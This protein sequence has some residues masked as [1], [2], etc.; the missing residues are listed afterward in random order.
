MS[1]N[2][3]FLCDDN[4]RLSPMAEAYLNVD[5]SRG[6]RAFS[7]GLSPAPDLAEGVGKILAAHGLSLTGL[8]P[9]SWRLF[10]LAHAPVPDV[11]VGLTP[12]ALGATGRAWPAHTRLVDWCIGTRATALVGREA[13]R[14]AFHEIRRRINRAMDEQSF[15][16][17]GFRRIA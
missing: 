2:V 10:T 6:L 3:L 16:H 15:R 9:K 12:A 5:P 17:S 11:V 8:Q 7:A 4:A 1:V 14:D 13:L